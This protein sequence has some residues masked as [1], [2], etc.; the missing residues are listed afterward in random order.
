MSAGATGSLLTTRAQP[1]ARKTDSRRGRM[2]AVA[3]AANTSAAKIVAHIG[4]PKILVRFIAYG[5]QSRHKPTSST[6]CR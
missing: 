4:H 1:A 2:A 3:I 6:I 5:A